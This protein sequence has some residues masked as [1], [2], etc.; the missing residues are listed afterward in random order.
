MGKKVM[1]YPVDWNLI[2]IVRK[3]ISWN[4]A[5]WQSMCPR[6][7]AGGSNPPIPFQT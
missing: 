5:Q 6:R 7:I 1:S 4:V 2:R 3:G